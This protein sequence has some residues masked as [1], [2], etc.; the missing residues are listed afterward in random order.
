MRV[1]KLDIVLGVIPNRKTHVEK[2][3]SPKK[4]WNFGNQLRC[5]ISEISS[6]MHLQQQYQNCLKYIYSKKAL[7]HIHNQLYYQIIESYIARIFT[8]AAL[9][10][11]EFQLDKPR[12]VSAHSAQK[13]ICLSKSKKKI[14]LT[15]PISV[16]YITNI[17]REKPC[18]Y[19]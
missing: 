13:V 12:N 1:Y 17:I 7:L 10:H 4:F 15:H 8:Y 18:K 6:Y 9:S 14:F 5:A 2:V 11:K 3:R 16:Y 19:L